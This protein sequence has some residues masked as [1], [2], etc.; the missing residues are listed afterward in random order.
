MF[1]CVEGQKLV[2]KVEDVPDAIQLE[3]TGL[4]IVAQQT[5]SYEEAKKV[6]QSWPQEQTQLLKFQ[7]SIRDGLTYM[8]IQL[9][10]GRVE[11]T[12]EIDQYNS[13]I[14]DLEANLKK[15]LRRLKQI[16]NCHG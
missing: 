3:I 14:H 8:T 13:Y 7:E 2:M 12:Q 5:E 16:I 6:S 4:E 10:E 11:L 9:I 1:E 15:R